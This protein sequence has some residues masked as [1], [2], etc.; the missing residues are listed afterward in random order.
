MEKKSRI[1]ARHARPEL[2][3]GWARSEFLPPAGAPMPGYIARKN[4]STGQA[5]PFSV[6][7][8][9]LQQRDVRVAILTAD[10]LLFSNRWAD[11]LRARLGKIAGTAK[12][13]IVVAAT[14]T[15]SGPIVDTAP[16]GLLQNQRPGSPGAQATMRRV[17]A[18]MVQSVEA[19]VASTHRVTAEM[20]RINVRGVATDR[21]N[22]AQANAQPLSL[23]RFSTRK[24]RA[25]LAV[26]GCHSTVLGP[27]NT[28]FSGDLHGEVG[29]RLEQDSEVALVGTGAAGNISTRFTRRA[30]TFEEVHRL[31]ALVHKQIR[32]AKFQRLPAT[33]ISVS[34]LKLRLPV[35]DLSKSQRA[36]RAKSGR[37]AVVEKEG[38]KVLAHL[39]T[40]PEFSRGFVS[41]PYTQITLGGISLVGLPF[42][43]FS[44]TGDYFWKSAKAVLL[45]Y[46]NGYWGYLPSHAASKGSYETLSSPYDDRADAILRNAVKAGRSC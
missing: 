9:V 16:F 41:I 15:H 3:A 23:L 42:E 26:Y 10:V 1:S 17:E 27:N 37:L 45:G 24:G 44:D 22:P 14:H 19:A 28:L 36:V 30:Q 8:L 31:A 20:A 2:L 5:D 12:Q 43:M 40:L 46:A 33:G 7:A 18:C 13:N 32:R 29:R 39:R 35:R 38:R 34:S 25:I 6:R 11:R 21:N 4:V